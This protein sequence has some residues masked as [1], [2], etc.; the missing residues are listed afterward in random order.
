[1]RTIDK[2]LL[3]SIVP[4]FLIALAVLTFVV[5]VHELGNLS[6]LLITRGASFPVILKTLGA[7]FP[8]ILVFSLPLSYLIGILIGLTGL[9]GES[10]ITAL[11]SCGVP[12]RTLLRCILLLGCIVGIVTGFFSLYVLPRS[13]D[14]LESVKDQ[15]SLTY[16]RSHIQPRVF[17]ED[18]PNIVFYIEDLAVDRQHWSNVFLVDNSDPKAART[19]IAHSGTWVTDSDNRRFQLHLERGTSYAVNP[20]DPGKDNVSLFVSTDIPIDLAESLVEQNHRPRRIAEQSSG[21]IWANYRNAPPA[22]QLQQLVELN[23]RLA[24]PFSILPFAL[25]GLTLAVS[26][27]KGGRTSGFALSLVTVIVFYM[28]FFNGLRLASVGKVSP[29]IGA[30]GADIFLTLAGLLLL[31]KVEKSY[32]LSQWLS[33]LLWKLGLGALIQRLHL[34][35]KVRKRLTR[36]DKLYAASKGS[37]ERFSFPKILDLYISRSFFIFFFWSLI[38]CGTLFILFTLFDLLDDII[39]NR[40]QIGYVLDYFIFLTPQILM[41]V[42]PMSVLLAILISFGIF[43][44]NSEITAIKAGGW[45]LFRI[46]IPVFLIASVFCASMFLLQ[47][48]VLPYANERQDRLRNLIKGR[49]P[50]TSSQLQRKWIFGESG[51]IYN[52]KYFDN[53]QDSF[54]D[55]NVY[56]INLKSARILRRTHAER[57]RIDRNGKWVLQN[58]WIR[59]YQSQQIGFR[60]I[61]T[62]AVHFP[63]NAGYFE[64]EIFQPKESSKLTY[65]KLNVYINYLMK[66]GYNATE[67]QVELY[68]RLSFPLSCMIMA[69]VAVPFSFSTGKK[70]AFF[71][72]GISIAIGIAYWGISSLFE[73]MGAYGM[74]IPVLA[75]WAP[76]ILFGSAGLA[77]FLT[78]R[79]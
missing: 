19:I 17:I 4:P 62:E 33:T 11:R 65:A 6:E 71:G 28:L 75:A 15:M 26:T 52:Y 78:V 67:L 66:S 9:S 22:E 23:R 13:N 47:D 35:E 40:I 29:W 37:Y 20:E 79:T 25:L 3:K 18:F 53:N 68:K 24:L 31:G 77:L 38:T 61:K 30:W 59:D 72:I 63:E 16:A 54:V 50:Q 7:I 21:Y 51:L 73:A 55:L 60:R 34:P 57:A 76:N 74:L 44:K 5:T 43:E 39:R 32:A 27:P 41:I 64:K 36:T 56:E 10:Q 46:A 49:P 2:I 70:G 45:S 42:V 14:V 48:K 8:R 58:G 69:L 12:L 1:M